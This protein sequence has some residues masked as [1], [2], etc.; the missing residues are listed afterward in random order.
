MNTP[1]IYLLGQDE[2]CGSCG[3]MLKEDSV[4]VAWNDETYCSLPCYQQ[5]RDVWE[6]SSG[7]DF[8]ASQDQALANLD[9]IRAKR[10][11]QFVFIAEGADEDGEPYISSTVF[12]HPGFC[13]VAAMRL[14]E[15]LDRAPTVAPPPD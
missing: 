4:I 3:M 8:Y 10:P 13:L 1:M 2:P 9:E 14:L 6:A 11:T 7:E 5:A 12:A 15:G